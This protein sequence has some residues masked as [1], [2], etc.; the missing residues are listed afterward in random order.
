MIRYNNV[1]DMFEMLPSSN[2]V[3]NIVLMLH[4]Y[5]DNAKGFIN[6]AEL[7]HKNV[8]DTLFVSINAINDCCKIPNG[9][10]WFPIADLDYSKLPLLLAQGVEHINKITG[11]YQSRYDIEASKNIIITGFSQGAMVALYSAIYGQNTLA[12]A[13]GFSGGFLAN[14]NAVSHNSTQVLIVHGQLDNIVT[15]DKAF[16]TSKELKKLDIK[17]KLVIEETLDHSI[18]PKGIKESTAL[19]QH[20]FSQ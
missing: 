1:Y 4:G 8:P 14:S 9:K 10:E 19:M 2:N 6:I 3:K 16:V 5:G 11:Y 7:W 20:I 17:A 18:G 13:I 12:A 15:V